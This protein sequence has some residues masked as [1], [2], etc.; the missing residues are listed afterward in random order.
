MR[1]APWT[2]GGGHFLIVASL[3]VR[4]FRVDAL[5]PEDEESRPY[6]WLGVRSAAPR[7]FRVGPGPAGWSSQPYRVSPLEAAKPVSATRQKPRKISAA[8][9]VQLIAQARPILV[10]SYLQHG[11][12]GGA[13]SGGS[14]VGRVPR[15]QEKRIQRCPLGHIHYYRMDLTLIGWSDR[16][17]RR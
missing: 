11:V 17:F 1:V 10:Q 5:R 2:A 4:D 8:P 16:Y 6:A 12:V 14:N 15:S 7:R 9:F 3:R 13:S